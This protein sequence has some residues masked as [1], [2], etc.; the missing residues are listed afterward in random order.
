MTKVG[1]RTRQRSR[2][3]ISASPAEPHGAVQHPTEDLMH[4]RRLT[5]PLSLLFFACDQDEGDAQA[6]DWEFPE[7][8]QKS[9]E[10]G[11]GLTSTRDTGVQVFDGY[12]RVVDAPVG[13]NCVL[14]EAGALDVAKFRAGGD[15]ISTELQFVTTRKEL[16]EKLGIDAQAKLKV[17]PLGGGGALSTSRT[18]RTSDKTLSILLRSRHMYTV[19]NQER[20]KVTP[21]ALQTLRSDAAQFTRECG[22]DYVSGVAYGAEL[23]M[24]VQIETSSLAKTKAVQTKLEAAGIKAGSAS[25]DPSLGSKFESALSDESV[26]VS[27]SVESRGFVPT[28]DLSQL[29]KLDEAAFKIAAEAQKQL[30]ASVEA[31]KCHDQG[32]SGPG[33][34]DGQKA[35]GYLANGGRVAVPM[36]VLRQQFQKTANFPGEAA[37]VDGLLATSRAADEAIS[38]LEDHAA[39]YDAMVAIHADEVNAM[40][41]SDRAYD[42]A[43][44]D[45]SDALREDI[46]FNELVARAQT[47]SAVYDPVSGTEVKKLAKLMAP[48]WSRA[49]FGDYSDCK[50]RPEDTTVGKEILAKFIEYS[51]ARIRPVFYDFSDKTLEEDAVSGECAAGSRPPTKSEAARLW[52]AL[53]RN[54]DIPASSNTE[55]HLTTDLGAWYDDAGKDCNGKEGAWIERLTTGAFAVGCYKGDQLLA[56]DMELVVFCVPKA[57]IYGANVTKLPGT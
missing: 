8:G 37:I 32:T 43:V 15:V 38:V 4:A 44:Y 47:W 14:P 12:N 26:R 52:N 17:G 54:P 18:F 57:G 28:V 23:L 13:R 24:L 51:T 55:G 50:T 46:D 6:D 34:C 53:E 27:A 19:I 30:R 3:H 42:F 49:Q 1:L 9:D 7:W 56:D 45:I 36:G 33:T 35:R 16:E 11:A 31:D 29:T 40:T 10:L 5:L 39:L 22:T 21:E 48:C 20:H 2:I 25:L 41:A